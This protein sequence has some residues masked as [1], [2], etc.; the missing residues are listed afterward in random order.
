MFSTADSSPS[1]T[2]YY[3]GRG[4]LRAADALAVEFD[5]L[6]L[7]KTPRDSVSFPWLRLVGALEAD[8]EPTTKEHMLETEALQVYLRSPKLQQ[9]TDNADPV[10]DDLETPKQK[11]LLKTMNESNSISNALR[12][13][14]Q[15]TLNR[16]QQ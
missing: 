3:K 8:D 16:S 2:K 5:E 15:K 7:S 12:A 13:Q 1:A 10:N 9:I 11:E 4:L 6:S 14:L